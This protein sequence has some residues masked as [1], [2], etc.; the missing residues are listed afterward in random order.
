MD[1]LNL[2]TAVI[3]KRMHVPAEQVGADSELASFA[4]DSFTLSEFL[5][6]LQ[7]RHHIHI[8]AE[9][10]RGLRTVRD[11]ALLLQRRIEA[12]KRGRTPF[13][14]ERTAS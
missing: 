13:S 1:Y 7:E 9:D 6:D 5:I 10:L 8:V 11:L 14:Y 4:V 2:V 3:A 12:G